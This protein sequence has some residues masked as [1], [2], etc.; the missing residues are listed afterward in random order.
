MENKKI[1]ICS[2]DNENLKNF[3]PLIP[4]FSNYEVTYFDLSNFHKNKINYSHK[5]INIISSNVKLEKSFYLLNPMKRLIK[6]L[7]FYFDLRKINHDYD[8]I[9][10]GRV[11]ILE[12]LLIK[13]FK[14]KNNAQSFSINDSVL[15]YHEQSSVFKKIRKIIYGFDV[16]QNICEK[17]FVSGEVSKQ[18]LLKDGVDNN[19]IIV[20]GLPRFKKYFK[21]QDKVQ[22]STNKNVL[23]IT[24]AHKW[25]GYN[26]W[27]DDQNM[28]LKVIN[29]L[30]NHSYKINVKPHPRDTFNFNILN[31]L[32]ILNSS[33]D[34]NKLINKHDIIVCATS[35]STVLIQAGLMSKK[36][37]FVKTRDL[38]HIMDSFR[39]YL[40][41]FAFKRIEHFDS[42]SFESAE[43]PKNDLLDMYI[44]NKSI[45]SSKIITDEIKKTI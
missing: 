2:I 10:T 27:Q 42:E 34:I 36:T 38:G 9:I 20:S 45:S 13:Y 43:L 39:F 44:S 25:N 8:I 4:Y 18:T 33:T 26:D 15:I 32:N 5:D 17:I 14:K 12:Y 6:S 21:L 28:F 40:D 1:L 29:E 23:I 30:K 24:G 7:A 41:N 35:I 11:G 19:K 3:E 16:R 22:K 37:L 31:N